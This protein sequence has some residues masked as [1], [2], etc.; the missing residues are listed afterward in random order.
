[1]PVTHALDQK[2]SLIQ[3]LSHLDILFMQAV[4][5]TPSISGIYKSINTT[6]GF[7]SP[8][9]TKASFR[10]LL[11]Q[12]TL[13]L[14]VYLR[15]MLILLKRLYDHQLTILLFSQTSSFSHHNGTFT[16]ILVRLFS[17]TILIV[18]PINA[19]LSRIVVMPSDFFFYI[20]FYK[21]ITLIYYF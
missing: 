5:S 20:L 1:M 7:A 6:S 16:C 14:P 4:A 10:Y 13:N 9:F 19:T 21:S 8:T 17:L 2:S 3:L 11:P 15:K 12:L 18:P